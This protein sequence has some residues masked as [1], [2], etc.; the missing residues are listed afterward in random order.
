MPGYNQPPIKVGNRSAPHSKDYTSANATSAVDLRTNHE[1]AKGPTSGFKAIGT[2]A[3]GTFSYKD[4]ANGTSRVVP[5]PNGG[6]VDLDG[7]AA[8]EI[9]AVANCT[10]I[11]YWHGTGL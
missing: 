5:V 10:V 9:S 6:F 3:A 11:A 1:V 8:I 2:A 4:C 7:I